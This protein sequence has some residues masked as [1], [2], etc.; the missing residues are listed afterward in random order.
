MSN[1]VPY[2]ETKIV[3]L[4]RELAMDIQSHEEILKAFGLDADEFERIKDDPHFKQ[5]LEAFMVEW[6][7]AANTEKRVKFKAQASIE[8]A[9]LDLHKAMVDP[10]NGLNHR[11]AAAQFISKLAG[12]G[13]DER[14][15]TQ[16]GSGFSITIN[17]G[18]T[19]AP[20]TIEGQSAPA[21]IE[22]A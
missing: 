14:Q 11:V 22:A 6:S 13:Q 8:A 1:T 17:M 16:T 15:A 3:E 19:S 18:E 5:V 20:I 10:A 12:L 4:A 9:L 21:Q 2:R 7:S